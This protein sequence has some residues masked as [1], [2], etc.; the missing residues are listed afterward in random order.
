MSVIFFLL[1]FSLFLLSIAVYFFWWAVDN[2]Q[3]DNLDQISKCI[4]LSD[5]DDN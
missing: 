1:P 3:F 5:N 4:L 2:D